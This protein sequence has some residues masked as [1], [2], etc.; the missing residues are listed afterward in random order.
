M[1][2]FYFTLSGDTILIKFLKVITFII[3]AFVVIYAFLQARQPAVWRH[4][5]RVNTYTPHP[6]HYATVGPRLREV[7]INQLKLKLNLM[8]LPPPDRPDEQVHYIRTALQRRQVALDAQLSQLLFEPAR[9]T[10][11]QEQVVAQ[12]VLRWEP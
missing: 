1:L 12:K 5:Y 10:P 8:D 7:F 9:L 6:Y 11:D 4:S 2:S 3:I